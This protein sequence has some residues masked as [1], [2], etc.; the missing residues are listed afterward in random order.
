MNLKIRP[1]TVDDLIN[2]KALESKAFP[3]SEA[4]TLEMITF[5]LDAAPDLFLIAEL[6]DRIV[7]FINALPTNVERLTN[8]F[9]VDAPDIDR[10]SVGIAA[11][12]L[13]VD[14]NFRRQGIAAR[15]MNVFIDQARLKR[16]QFITFVCKA[17]K[18][19]YYQKFGFKCV[20]VSSVTLGGARWHDMII[21]L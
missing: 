7:G 11:M 12:S 14:Q 10:N 9:Y 15:L 5:R 13:A 21:N 19:S 3:S 18:I 1:A 8:N 16:K 6:D 4:D 17:E 20:G 2:V